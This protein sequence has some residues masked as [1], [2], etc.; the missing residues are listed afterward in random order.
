M[1]T[2]LGLF[3][4]TRADEVDQRPGGEVPGHRQEVEP[5][6]DLVAEPAHVRLDEL[7][8]RVGDERAPST[9][10]TCRRRIEATRPNVMFD[11]IARRYRTLPCVVV[12]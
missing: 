3:D 7:A 2:T 5:L 8:H 4:R 1:A 6:G 11:E 10:S 12:R 9:T